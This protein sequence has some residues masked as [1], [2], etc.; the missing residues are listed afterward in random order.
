MFIRL[1]A[2]ASA[3]SASN[4]APTFFPTSTSAISMDKIEYADPESK[5]FARTAF[6]IGIGKW[7]NKSI[8]KDEVKLKIKSYGYGKRVFRLFRVIKRFRSY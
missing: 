5:P 2:S 6:E 1:I 8:L 4:W 3:W 7:K